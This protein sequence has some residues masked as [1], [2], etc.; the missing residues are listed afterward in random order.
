MNMQRESPKY[1]AYNQI[2]STTAAKLV[3]T[4]IVLAAMSWGATAGIS[5]SAAQETEVAYVASVS[6]RVVALSRGTPVMLHELDPVSDRTRLDLQAHSE[7]HI[8]HYGTQRLLTLRGPSRASVSADGI[9]VETGKTLDLS[10]GPC[11]APV[12][13]NHQGGLVARGIAAHEEAGLRRNFF[14]K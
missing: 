11:A 1:T 6:G 14:G 12:V 9:T 5:Q 4:A 8:C 13:S 3:R 2:R 7:L 10:K